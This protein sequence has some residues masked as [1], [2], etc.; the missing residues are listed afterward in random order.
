MAWLTRKW[1]SA[2]A[3]VPFSLFPSPAC[4]LSASQLITRWAD[5]LLMRCPQRLQAFH[6]SRICIQKLRLRSRFGCKWRRY[7]SVF[8]VLTVHWWAVNSIC[9]SLIRSWWFASQ[10]GL[11]RWRGTKNKNKDKR[12]GVGKDNRVFKGRHRLVAVKS[13]GVQVGSWINS[14]FQLSPAI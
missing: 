1:N 10:C 3:K 7:E 12:W 14:T 5:S 9:F 6:F 8:V 4:C 2:R 13:L 11:E